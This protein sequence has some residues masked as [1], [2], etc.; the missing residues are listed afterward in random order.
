MVY[1]HRIHDYSK[2][3]IKRNFLRSKII[4]SYIFTTKLHIKAVVE[5]VSAKPIYRVI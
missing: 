2:P 5:T 1:L 4:G 3:R